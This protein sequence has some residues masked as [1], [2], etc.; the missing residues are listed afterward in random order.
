MIAE[1]PAKNKGEAHRSAAFWGGKRV[2]ILR[3]TFP[4]A[5]GIAAVCDETLQQIIL[6]NETDFAIYGRNAHEADEQ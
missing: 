2:E 6:E 1:Y 4:A 5:E 3:K